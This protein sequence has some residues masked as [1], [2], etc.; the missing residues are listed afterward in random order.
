MLRND[1][2]KSF[3]EMPVSDASVRINN[4]L[5]N[6]FPNLDETVKSY[7]VEVLLH[8]PEDFIGGGDVYELISPFIIESLDPGHF[9]SEHLRELCD[10]LHATC[11]G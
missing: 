3:L 7:I 5:L 2:E 4:I 1:L 10:Q 6:Y 11:I 9:D 8:N